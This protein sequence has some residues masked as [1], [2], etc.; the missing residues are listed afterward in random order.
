M[1]S[2]PFTFVVFDDQTFGRASLSEGVKATD[3]VVLGYV[4]VGV[5]IRILLIKF[6]GAA[7]ELS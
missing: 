1:E 3:I 5:S 6:G 4:E 2:V 7:V